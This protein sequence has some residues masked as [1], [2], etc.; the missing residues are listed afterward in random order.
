MRWLD[1]ITDSV[2]MSLSKLQELVINREAWNAAVHGVARFGHGWVTELNWFL[3]TVPP[4]K[5][6]TSFLNIVYHLVFYWSW[7]FVYKNV[8]VVQLVS[9]AQF[10]VTP[11]TAALQASLTSLSPRVCSNSCP[12]SQWYHPTISSSVTP[13]F[14]C[15]KSFPSLGSFPLSWLFIS[16]D[17]S[18]G[19]SALASF[20]PMNVQGWFPLGLMDWISLLSRGLSRVFSNTTLRKH[21]FFSAQPFYGPIL[22]SIL[23]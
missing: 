2:D 6:G 9:H 15:P 13:F 12:L 19:A 8:V 17:Q 18:T 10:F 20:L 21:Q 11:W 14:S 1:G 4:G 7:D 3:S 5:S 22:T 16:G 23:A